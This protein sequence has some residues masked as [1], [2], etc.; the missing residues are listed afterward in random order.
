MVETYSKEVVKEFALQRLRLTPSTLG[1][2]KNDVPSVVRAIGGLQDGGHKIELFNRFENF[3]PEWFDYWYEN[4]ALIDGHVLRGALRIVNVDE[5]PYF[6]MATRSVARRRAAYQKCPLS[7]NNNHLL[8]FNFIEKYGPFTPSEFKKLFSIKFPQLKNMARKLFYDLYNYG[9]IARMGGKKQKP[10]YHAI[11]KLPYKLDLSQ[12]GEKEAK[13]WLFLKCLSIYGPFTIKDIAHWVGWNI[14][15]TKEILGILLE[16]KKVKKVKI[17]SHQENHYVRVEDLALLNLLSNDLPESSFI[18]ILFNDDALLLGYYRRL[19]NYFGYHWKY[20]QFG[21]G[22]VWRAAILY[23]RN[24]IGEA[25]VEMYAKSRFFKVKKLI[26]RKEFVS[27]EI[28]FKIEDEFMRHAE[29]QNK[30]LEMADPKLV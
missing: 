14:T 10:L 22:I 19:R 30:I 26:L 9:K 11:E 21:E 27:S 7:L 2:N 29:F 23:G 13:E 20:P 24:L 28:S 16:K 4:Y 12:I 3:K 15:E 6:F 1:K 8:A 17:E 5:Y 25:I 18:R